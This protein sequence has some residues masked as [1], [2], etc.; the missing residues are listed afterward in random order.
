VPLDFP[1]GPAINDTWTG[2]NGVTYT[3]NGTMWTVS[4]SGVGPYLPLSGGTM[5]GGDITLFRD[6]TQPLHA[7][8]RSYV[9][10]AI[11]LAGNYLGTWSVAANSPNISAGGAISNANYVAVTANP[12]TPEVVPVGV[13]GIAG[14]TVANGDR[15]IWASGLGTWQILRNAGVTLAAADARYVALGGSV[16][17]GALTL[18]GNAASALQAVPLQQ[19][20]VAS[21]TTP[22]MDGTATVGAG[23]T[24]AKADHIHPTD[25]SR[26]SV[27]SVTAAG[28]S[29]ANNVG[30]N[31]IHN[32][33]FNV[34]QRGGGPWTT[35]GYTLDRWYH[36]T[37]TD[38]FSSSMAPLNDAHRAAI[39]DE[40][41]RFA[42][43]NTFTGNAAAGA[44][45]MLFQRIEGVRR[46][47][48]KTITLSFWAYCTSGA[49]NLGA[50]IDQVFGTGGSPS[51]YVPGNGTAVTLSTAFARYSVTLSVPSVSGK[52]LGTNGDDFTQVVFWF[53][54]GATNALRSGN[55]GVQSGAIALWGV[56]LEIGSVTTPLE[57]PDPQVEL[58]NCQRFYQGGNMSLQGYGVTG[59]T[60]AMGN[61]FPVSMRAAPTMVPTF[62]TQ[63]NCSSPALGTF[64]NAYFQ[65]FA[66]VTATGQMVLGGPFTASADL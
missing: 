34:A 30:R 53:S 14:L 61:P 44:F 38:T 59:V 52:T 43:S 40:A 25:T 45:N 1:S 49:L 65:Y 13:P 62:T 48:G 66:T 12:A 16:M 23:T 64:N 11:N 56:Q 15:I 5:T 26:A 42:Y 63:V 28:A 17:T 22:A 36:Q 54:S 35:G 46:H 50:S 41:A 10:N 29:A 9:D 20:P 55:V 58:A 2:S 21:S 60:L 8:P 57:K 39:G 6:P 31:L 37:A 27:A 7:S 33:M 19:V 3:W 4:G 51:A 32:S 47:A 24:W 18:S